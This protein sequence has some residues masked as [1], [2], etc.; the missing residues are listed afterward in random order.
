LQIA[1]RPTALSGD[2]D[3]PADLKWGPSI[4]LGAAIIYLLSNDGE[5]V[6]P[7]L[8]A[9]NEAFLSSIRSD[10]NNRLL[11]GVVQRSF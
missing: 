10:K 8:V 6:L 4:A 1:K 11:G 5:D 7:P 9:L 3:A 2:S